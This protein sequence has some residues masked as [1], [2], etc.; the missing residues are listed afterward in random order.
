MA[1]KESDFNFF[2]RVYN[3]LIPEITDYY[4]S[5]PAQIPTTEILKEFPSIIANQFISINIL[6]GIN[7]E[8]YKQN[9]SET[10]DLFNFPSPKLYERLNISLQK[11][12]DFENLPTKDIK[13]AFMKEINKDFFDIFRIWHILGNDNS[14][15]LWAWSDV[16]EL[17]IS[18][19][20]GKNKGVYYTHGKKFNL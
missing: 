20:G 17:H 14:D 16:Y 6:L 8:H 9:F 18:A 5:F 19:S 4:N 7:R 10:L 1:S 15:L 2:E 11:F 12:I 3:I 13:R